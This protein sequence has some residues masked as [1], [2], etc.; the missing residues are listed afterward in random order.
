MGALMTDLHSM[1]NYNKYLRDALSQAR[2][3]GLLPPDNLPIPDNN[4]PIP[5]V[6]EG[7]DYAWHAGMPDDAPYQPKWWHKL[8]HWAFGQ[9][10]SLEM[11]AYAH[12]QARRLARKTEM[13][14]RLRMARARRV[15][16]QEQA[17]RI[18]AARHDHKLEMDKARLQAELAR[19]DQ[20]AREVKAWAERWKVAGRVHVRMSLRRGDIGGHWVYVDAVIEL[21]VR[22][23]M[24]EKERTAEVVDLAGKDGR[25]YPVKSEIGSL[26]M[27]DIW[28][29]HVAPWVQTGA[30]EPLR[31][32]HAKDTKSEGDWRVYIY[33]EEQEAQHEAA[34]Q[35]AE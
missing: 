35:T 25:T 13:Q 22:T 19:E 32:L 20:A 6:E 21:K 29:E 34:R 31:A 9:A 27:T 26:S 24:G 18:A 33:E 11:R 14:D 2:M 17:A 15:Q 1:S 3:G 4:L 7:L 23:V 16:E 30:V 8:F 28:S 5:P 12:E 10:Y